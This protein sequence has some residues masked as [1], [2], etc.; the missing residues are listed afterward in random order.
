MNNVPKQ[1]PGTAAG[2]APEG[3]GSSTTTQALTQRVEPIA[4]SFFII[5]VSVFR[6][7]SSN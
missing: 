4:Q 2:I 6:R 3:T 5:L 1:S 7:Y